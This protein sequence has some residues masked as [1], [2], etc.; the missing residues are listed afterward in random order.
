MLP[1]VPPPYR[2]RPPL[3]PQ[4][5]SSRA[6]LSLALPDLQRF[7][8]R[9]DIIHLQPNDPPQDL[10]IWG[11]LFYTLLYAG[12]GFFIAYWIFRRKEL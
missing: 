2:T 6:A 5:D 11:L 1:T 7:S 8:L 3:R 12:G 10:Y 9:H 4:S